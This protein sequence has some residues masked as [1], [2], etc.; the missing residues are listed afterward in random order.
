M[1]SLAA[2][3]RLVQA[4]ALR[5]AGPPV[6]RRSRSKGSARL[7]SASASA[8][9][10]PRAARRCS[11]ATRFPTPTSTAP[12]SRSRISG[13]SPAPR[14]S[15]SA[16]SPST[17]QDDLRALLGLP[18]HVVPVAWL[19][20]G[21][22]DERPLR[23]GLEAAG[24]Q[25]A[26]AGRR[27]RPRR[28]L[29]RA[30]RPPLGAAPDAAALRGGPS[31]DRASG[32]VAA[33]RGGGRARRSRRCA[34]AV[35]DASDELVKPA[36]SLGALEVMLE[37]CA[38]PR[39]ARRRRT[40]PRAGDPRAS[41]PITGSRAQSVSL[42]PARVGAQVAAA[43]AR[44]ETAIG[45][46]ARGA[47]RRAARRR[48][49]AARPASRPGSST[50]AS[51]PAA[52]T[53]ASGPA[54][55]SDAAAGGGRGR[56]RARERARARDATCSC[57][58]RSGSATRRSPR[59]CSPALTGLAPGRGLRARYR[60]RCPG[61]RAQ[62]GGRRSQRSRRTPSRE[63]DTLECLR[64]ARRPRVSPRS[65]ARCSARRRPAAPDPAR[66]LRDRRRGARAAAACDPR[67]ATT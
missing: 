67:F 1:Q 56:V 42:Y 27:V 36:G 31:R 35:R 39:R 30:S 66:R 32:V 46:L 58:V 61:P 33:A 19:C 13:C 44:G 2:R 34:F 6:P 15:A 26:P 21:Y 47:R 41:P 53:S 51:P 40:Q 29:G 7:R 11:A 3:E 14:G 64:R 37:R 20:V 57:S 65:S 24:W 45:V 22:P 10:E 55:S 43:A 62:G 23:P 48:R 16:G 59:R 49:R 17:G 4:D 5:R 12:A 9:T 52:P 18:E 50:G 28:A 38:T 63:T 25:T 60:P 8:A 54:L